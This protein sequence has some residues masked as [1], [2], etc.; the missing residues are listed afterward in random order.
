MHRLIAQQPGPDTALGLVK[1]DMI[2]LHDTSTPG[3]LE[4]SQRHLS[5]GCVCV[6]DA[7]GFAQL[8]GEDEGV[9]DRWQ[10]ANASGVED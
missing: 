9:A 10:A 2:Y 5:H 4:R 8:L 3:L 1:F 6:E 7:W